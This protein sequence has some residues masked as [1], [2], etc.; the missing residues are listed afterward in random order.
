MKRLFLF[1]G[2]LVAARISLAQTIVTG[3]VVDPNG[4]PYANGTASAVS[5]P[6]SGQPTVYTTPVPTSSTGF[7]TMPLAPNTYIFTLCA[8]PVQIGPLA[9][10]TPKQ[11]CFSSGPVVVSGSN[12]DVSAL[13]G[14]A[15]VIGP[16]GGG[17]VTGVPNQIVVTN[18]STVGLANPASFPGQVSFPDPGFLELTPHPYCYYAGNAL[19]QQYQICYLQNVGLVAMPF[20]ANGFNEWMMVTDLSVS[21]AFTPGQQCCVILANGAWGVV[22][23]LPLGTIAKGGSVGPI[24]S[25]ATDL[26]GTY[27]IV[28]PLTAVSLVSTGRLN[29]GTAGGQAWTEGGPPTTQIGAEIPFADIATHEIG[30]FSNGG[31]KKLNVAVRPAPIHQT[32][33][34]ASISTATLC[35]AALGNCDQAGQYHVHLDF[36]NT[37]TACTNVTAGS[38]GFQLTWTDT[39][40]TQHAAVQVPMMTQASATALAGT[41]V[42]VAN[43]LSAWGSGDINISTNGSVIQYATNYTAC[44]TGTGTYQLD[45][46]VTRLE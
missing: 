25:A 43:N 36:I 29:G 8:P 6:N 15:A 14:T 45:A 42:F 23:P 46:S 34:T 12:Q 26:N 37:G 31:G 3:T 33:Q 38:V 30:I 27:S 1:L 10:P 21:Q 28:E 13:L 40:G 4:N 44:T 17:G 19:L 41:M 39:N 32:A 2:L 9:N 5:V 24:A 35:A 16:V 20:G 7:F 11:I 18:N 22:T